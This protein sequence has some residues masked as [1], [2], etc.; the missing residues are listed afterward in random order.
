MDHPDDLGPRLALVEGNAPRV[1]LP[2][3]KSLGAGDQRVICATLAAS[4]W[5]DACEA[6]PLGGAGVARFLGTDRATVHRY[7]TGEKLL[8]LRD[9]IAAPPVVQQRVLRLAGDR[10]DGP[11]SEEGGGLVA[12]AILACSEAAQVAVQLERGSL[13][14]LDARALDGLLDL[15]DSLLDRLTRLRRRIWRERQRRGG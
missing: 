13:E 10:L 7:G 14:R 1:V 5:R 6:Y 11:R 9:V 2:R 12:D 3:A 4:W 8:P 15:I